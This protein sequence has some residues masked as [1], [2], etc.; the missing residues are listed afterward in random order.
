M[1]SNNDQ[2]IRLTQFRMEAWMRTFNNQRTGWAMLVGLCAALL[3][4]L[5]SERHGEAVPAGGSFCPS[6]DSP[7]CVQCSGESCVDAC[8]GDF[9]CGLSEEG[10]CWWAKV[11]S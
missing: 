9:T 3:L 5:G 7:T 11:C 2:A 4:V 1:I 10:H 6:G 8:V